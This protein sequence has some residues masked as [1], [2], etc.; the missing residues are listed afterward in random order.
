MTTRNFQIWLILAPPLD[1]SGNATGAYCRT[2]LSEPTRLVC[3]GSVF[4]S[5]FCSHVTSSGSLAKRTRRIQFCNGISRPASFKLSR[6]Q[7]FGPDKY[8]KQQSSGW[9][10]R[11]LLQE[12]YSHPIRTL[13]QQD[14][15]VPRGHFKIS[16]R[17]MSHHKTVFLISQVLILA[18]Y[19]IPAAFDWLIITLTSHL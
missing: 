12:T 17:Q 13:F 9:G 14:S 6:L 2:D 15:Q 19:W 4:S 8:I 1:R 5:I 10:S 3:N 16:G 18:L 7:G 11:L